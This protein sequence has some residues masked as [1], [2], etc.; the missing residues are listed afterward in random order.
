MSYNSKNDI[1]DSYEDDLI[2]EFGDKDE[3]ESISELDSNLRSKDENLGM[4]APDEEYIFDKSYLKDKTKKRR[5]RVI[6]KTVYKRIYIVCFIIIFACIFL[7]A[8]LISYKVL[9]REE[10]NVKELLLYKDKAIIYD[11]TTIDKKINDKVPIININNS[12]VNDINNSINNIYNTYLI[13]NPDY[14]R[15]DYSINDD[16]ISLVLIY[17][18]KLEEESNYTYKFNTYNISLKTL[19]CLTDKQ[20]LDKFRLNNYDV[21]NRMKKDFQKT[22]DDLLTKNFISE[23]YDYNKLIIDL[24]LSNYT[25]GI[26]YYIDN[27]KLYVYKFFNIYNNQNLTSY[28]NEYNYKFYIK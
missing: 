26:N 11:N 23:T 3:E 15:Y 22:Y 27:N 14:F 12:S 28:F 16:T 17:R 4:Q 8:L 25:V 5:D 24:E 6:D 13:N 1:D 7:D 18:N 2:N 21:Y 20:I 19:S 9:N 10:Y